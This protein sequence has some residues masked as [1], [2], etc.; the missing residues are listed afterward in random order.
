MIISN[1]QPCFGPGQCEYRTLSA[2]EVEKV[3]SADNDEVWYLV[4]VSMFTG[5]ALVYR[6]REG[7]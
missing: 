6:K 4:R 7:R 5:E 3:G 2:Q 1:Q